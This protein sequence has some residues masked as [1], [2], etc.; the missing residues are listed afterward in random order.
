MKSYNEF[1]EHYGYDKED[2]ESRKLYA[3][4]Q[5]QAEIFRRMKK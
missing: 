1:C 4:Y 3:E 5:K 2:E